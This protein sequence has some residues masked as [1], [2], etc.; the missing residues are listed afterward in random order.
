MEWV[1]SPAAAAAYQD[2]LAEKVVSG[3]GDV[4]AELLTTGFAVLDP[5]SDNLVALPPEVP[6][7]RSL[8]AM[9]HDW[10]SRRPD[11]AAAEQDLMELAKQ[12]RRIAQRTQTSQLV[13]E[14]PTLE[15]RAVVINAAWTGARSELHVFQPDIGP[16]PDIDSPEQL[17]FAPEDL[18]RRGVTIRFLYERAILDDEDFLRAALEE[19]EIGVQARV[20]ATLP[21]LAMIVD[22]QALYVHDCDA[23]RTLISTT[24]LPIVDTFLAM[25]ESLWVAAVPIGIVNLD[26]A[27]R[28]LTDSHKLILTNIVA[29][30][31]IDVIART[32]KIDPRTVRR[33]V[34]DLCQM[35]GVNSRV[36]LMSAALAHMRN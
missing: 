22:R 12:D 9:T 35:F 32:L 30:R 27:G 10:F 18:L 8:A 16:R 17:N 24:A 34:D 7:V 14:S 20:T 31:P 29:G 15:E 1:L 13:T 5:K 28:E 4:A 33:K 11:M 21:S 25:F 2:L 23:Q 6:I 3:E 19:V 36:E 26:T